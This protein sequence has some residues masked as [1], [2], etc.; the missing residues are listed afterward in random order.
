MHGTPAA[1]SRHRFVKGARRLRVAIIGTGLIGS[2][3]G[4]AL[5]EL[6]EVETVVGYDRD[7]ARLAT[8][9][10]RGAIAVAALAPPDAVRDADVVVLAVPASAMESIIRQIAGTLASGAIVTDVASV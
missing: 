2:S 9:L 4:L 1:Y 7:A 5:Q 10:S 6:L 8:A 3:L